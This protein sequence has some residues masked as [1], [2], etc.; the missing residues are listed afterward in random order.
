M[1]ILIYSTLILIDINGSNILGIFDCT[2]KNFDSDSPDAL[3]GHQDRYVQATYDRKFACPECG[4]RYNRRNNLIR[5]QRY[6]CG[7]TRQFCC[8]YCYD[9]M[10]RKAH[11][12]VHVLRHHPELAKLFFNKII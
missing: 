6:E 10:K 1:L 7:N 9:K 11:L 4:R 12:E 5:H 2:A 3:E 8:P